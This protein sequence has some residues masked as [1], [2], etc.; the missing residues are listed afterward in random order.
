[1][2]MLNDW[3]KYSKQM[4][5]KDVWIKTVCIFKFENVWINWVNS[6]M[7]G[8]YERN[9]IVKAYVPGLI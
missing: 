4:I 7:K 9:P 2:C 1:M 3:N 5:N 6:W 8:K